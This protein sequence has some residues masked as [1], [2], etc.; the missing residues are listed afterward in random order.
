ML[1]KLALGSAQ[2]GANYGVANKVGKPSENDAIII[3]RSAIESGIKI[4]D[5][6]QAYGNSEEIIG[7]AL[8]GID[9][10]NVVV[11]T[12]LSPSILENT[13]S[14]KDIYNSVDNS[15]RNS[16]KALKAESIDILMLHRWSHFFE[17][18]HA[19]WERLLYWQN[20]GLIT[21]LG[22][23]ITSPNE[24]MEALGVAQVKFIQM[25]FNILDWR[26][27]NDQ[28]KRALAKR[29]DVTIQARSVFLQ[30][31]LISQEEIWPKNLNIHA[32]DIIRQLEKL[33][34]DFKRKNRTD[35]CIAYLRSLDWI[36]NIVIGVEILTQLEDNIKLFREPIL[37]KEQVII[38]EET[39][40]NLPETLLNP[41][42]W[43][44]TI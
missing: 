4:I 23:S 11:A 7:R 25:P 8:E 34:V 13:N 20:Q 21:K 17:K 9:R 29:S 30:G 26:F 22:A 19:V 12:K 42:M 16:L 43:H 15:L 3:I 18:D 41:S 44:K 33:V 27:R 24:A 35:L 2:I 32:T 40:L 5:T 39:F 14:K 37:N 6:A 36:D 10:R 38:I 1:D 28:I 31:I